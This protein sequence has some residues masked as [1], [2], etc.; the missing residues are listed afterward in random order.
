MDNSG[1][2]I[3]RVRRYLRESDASISYWTDPFLRQLLNAAYRRRCSQL[4]MAFEGYFTLIATRDL[5]SGKSTYGFP[6][7]TLRC[8]KLELVR[9]DGTRTP[10]ER[11]ER[12]EV[13][14]APSSSTGAGDAY[15]PTYRPISNGFILE[16]TPVQDVTNGI[17]IEYS[18][19][20]AYMS[21][22]SDSPHIAFPETFDELLVMDTT[23]AA[24][25]AQ[26][27]HEVGPGAAITEMR[28]DWE[29]DWYRFIEQR[30]VARERVQPA[31]GPWTDY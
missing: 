29:I 12:I 21:N 17:R 11:N 24:L 18:G 23:I 1:Q 28:S 14:V 2:L 4:I 19:V 25:E 13:G 3:T 6:S 16:P 10:I 26:R 7:G 27:M 5:E 15:Y 9:S 31:Y 8:L 20:P 30:I 22:D